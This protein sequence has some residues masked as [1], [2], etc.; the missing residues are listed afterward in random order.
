MEIIGCVN[1]G[2]GFGLLF[3]ANYV[4]NKSKELTNEYPR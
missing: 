3:I 4:L 1:I 2:L